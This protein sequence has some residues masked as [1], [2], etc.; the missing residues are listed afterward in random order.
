[1]KWRFA[2]LLCLNALFD[3]AQQQVVGLIG[4]ESHKPVEESRNRARIELPVA[5]QK[6]FGSDCGSFLP[7]QTGKRD[8]IRTEGVCEISGDSPV[9]FG[10]NRKNSILKVLSQF[11]ELPHIGNREDSSA[12]R[13]GI[14][15]ASVGLNNGDVFFCCSSE[16]AQVI[17]GGV[18]YINSA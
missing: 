17:R 16:D 15:I 9:S 1:M 14:R 8:P 13:C 18:N 7:C 3:S 2:V 5:D 11:S 10:V 6:E 12:L 4:K